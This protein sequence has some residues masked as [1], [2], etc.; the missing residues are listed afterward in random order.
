[1]GK[2]KS[3]HSSEFPDQGHRAVVAIMVLLMAISCGW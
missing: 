1:M 3:S 2:L